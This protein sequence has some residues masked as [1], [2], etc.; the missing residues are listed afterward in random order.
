MEQ[1]LRIHVNDKQKTPFVVLVESTDHTPS[2]TT[3]FE[4]T[5]QAT[6]GPG[7]SSASNENFVLT[8]QHIRAASP[9]TS[10]VQCNYELTTTRYEVLRIPVKAYY[11]DYT[12]SN[13]F[14]L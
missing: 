9:A 10:M 1:G 4:S 7:R 12:Y 2:P 5:K 13:L 6:T 3:N 8:A 11:I 14:T